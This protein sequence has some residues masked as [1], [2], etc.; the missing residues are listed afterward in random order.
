MKL[1]A[2][3]L[4][5][6]ALSA[7]HDEPPVRPVSALAAGVRVEKEEPP[8]GARLVGEVEGADGEGCGIGGDRGS[9]QNATTALKEAA[10]R[11]GATYV[12]LTEETKPY[13]GRDCVHLQYKLRGLAYALDGSAAPGAAPVATAVASPAATAPPALTACTPPCSPGYA[14]NAAGVCVAE[15]NPPCAAG[16][17]CRADR[18]C[19]PATP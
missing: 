10:A 9:L 13:S 6:A 18:V 8:A 19:V 4:L 2:L 7:C 11:K 15:C 14:C 16:Q 1:I 17:Q 12:K 5:A 3:L